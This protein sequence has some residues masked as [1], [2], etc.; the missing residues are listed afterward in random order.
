MIAEDAG[1]LLDIGEMRHV[2]EAQRLVGEERR[3]HQRQ[4]GILGARDRD[5][6]VQLVAADYPDT[7]HAWSPRRPAGMLASNGPRPARL[8]RRAV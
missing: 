7:I 8:A 3:D 6:P 5:R 1:E 2:F 4:G